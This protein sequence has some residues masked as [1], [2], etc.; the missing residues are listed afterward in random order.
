M[1]TLIYVHDPMC[2]WCW[3]FASGWEKIR[4][5]LP[6][7]VE[8]KTLIGGLAPDSDQPMP[9]DMQQFLAQTWRRIEESVPGTVFNHGFWTDCQPRRSTWPACRAVCAAETLHSGAGQ[10]MTTAIQKAYYTAARNPSDVETLLDLAESIALDKKEF[11]AL[12]NSD[13]NRAEHRRQMEEAQSLGVDSYPTLLLQTGQQIGRLPLDYN[14]AD[15]TL[16][17]IRSVIDVA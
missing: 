1:N 6:E 14:N 11:E 2:S 10:A 7:G 16:K 8:V 15:A 17:A 4:S 12:I 9:Q 3:A 13:E 5:E